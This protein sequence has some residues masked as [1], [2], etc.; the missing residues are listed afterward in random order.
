MRSFVAACLVVV[1]IA[2]GAAAVLNW[3]VQKSAAQ[4]FATSGVRL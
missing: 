1:V 2:A 3:G 4:A